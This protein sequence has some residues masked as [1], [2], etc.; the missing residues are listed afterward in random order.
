M[1]KYAAHIWLEPSSGEVKFEAADR[2]QAMEFEGGV[3]QHVMWNVEQIC[4][5]CDAPMEDDADADFC[6][7]EC[8]KEYYA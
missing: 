5:Q 3:D 8:S 2:E 1:P 7:D 6:S 4:L